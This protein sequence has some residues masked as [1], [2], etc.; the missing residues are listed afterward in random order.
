VVKPGSSLQQF[1]DLAA[2][3]R[4]MVAAAHVQQALSARV[5][6]MPVMA[7]YF[8]SAFGWGIALAYQ[9]V[10]LD[11]SI[12]NHLTAALLGPALAMLWEVPVRLLPMLLG[13]SQA[14]SVAGVMLC[15]FF[16]ALLAGPTLNTTMPRDPLLLVAPAANTFFFVYQALVGRGAELLSPDLKVLVTGVGLVAFVAFSRAAGIISGSCTKKSKHA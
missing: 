8:H 10:G 16:L 14:A 1:G 13:A 2:D 12:L 11:G 15:G 6:G 3:T 7:P 5:F 4:G 9:W